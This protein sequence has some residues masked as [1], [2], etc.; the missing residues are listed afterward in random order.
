MTTTGEQ[1]L[2]ER[3]TG[4]EVQLARLGA[5]LGTKLDSLIASSA[6]Q[7]SDHERR[8]RALEQRPEVDPEHARRMSRLEQRW[9]LIV[10]AAFT[11]GGVGGTIVP[12]LLPG[13]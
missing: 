6:V 4:L 2:T 9:Y 13:P 1:Q 3:I 7:G 8:I 11:G 5:T 12:G 10:A